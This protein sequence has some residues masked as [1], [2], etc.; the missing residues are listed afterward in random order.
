MTG[1]H[2]VNFYRRKEGEKVA[3]LKVKNWAEFQHYKNRAPPWIK[4]HKGLLNDY[5]FH[6]L[7]VA[8]RAL[9]PCIWLLASEGESGALRFDVEVIAFRLRQSVKDTAKAIIPL[10]NKGFLFVSGED[11]SDALARCKQHACL[12][13]ETEKEKEEDT[14]HD[15]PPSDPEKSKKHRKK[16]QL[17][18]FE[19]PEWIPVDPWNG[20]LEMRTLQ[21][22]PPTDR[23]KALAVSKLEKLRAKGHDPG[24]VLDRSTLNGWTGL[25]ERRENNDGKNNG[26]NKGRGQRLADKLDAIAREAIEREGIPDYVDGSSV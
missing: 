14:P 19:L 12:E 25:F 7:P 16:A 26:Y 11:A 20:W 13:L 21:R 6:C 5:E 3:V 1:E 22:K 24:E 15:I 23:A 18:P 17:L 2:D 10:I 4:L 8:S 9:A